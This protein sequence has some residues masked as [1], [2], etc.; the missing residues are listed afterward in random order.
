M[1]SGLFVTPVL[2]WSFLTRNHHNLWGWQ[3]SS[4]STF[5]PRPYI[6][7]YEWVVKVIY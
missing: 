5:N 7:I 2:T 1:I 3:S 4:T 6:F